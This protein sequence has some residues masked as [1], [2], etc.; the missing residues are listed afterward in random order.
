[1]VAM[2]L[3]VLIGYTNLGA[4]GHA[5]F[6]AIGAYTT[7]ILETKYN[8]GFAVSFFSTIGVAAGAS[9][10]L[11]F[12]VLRT[13]GIYFLL[14]TLSIAMSVW[15]LIYRWVSLTGGDNGIRTFPARISVPWNL[16]IPSI[17]TISSC[18]LYHLLCAPLPPG[19]LPLR[20]DAGGHPGQ[21]IADEGVG[22]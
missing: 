4:L 14:I 12:L 19:P 17:S 15:G 1:M 22:L 8:A 18:L 6:F 13:T 16:C 9:A 3:D 20:Q 10:L 5:A 11:A 21:R 7:A 2:S